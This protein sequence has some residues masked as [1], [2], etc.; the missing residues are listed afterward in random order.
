MTAA[1]LVVE[2]AINGATTRRRNPHVPLTVEELAAD[3]LA[4][5]DAGAAIVHHHVEPDLR[6]DDAASRYLQV[7][8]MVWAERPDA[9]L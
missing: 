5:F 1:P 8:E 4:C 2:A 7:W 3:A 9:L 6:G